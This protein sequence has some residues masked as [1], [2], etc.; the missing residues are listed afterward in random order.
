MRKPFLLTV[1][2][3]LG[4]YLLLPLPG[5]SSSLDS[6]IGKTRDRLAGKKHQEGILTT[7]LSHYSA[8]IQVL[9]GDIGEL[10]Q[11]QDRVQVSLN[12]KQA[13]LTRVS[14][15]HQIVQNRLTK[16]RAKLVAGR[17]LLARR[18]VAL[19]KDDQPDMV[20]VVLE[21][22]GFTDLLDR[23]D[24]IQRISDQNETI[25]T[26][27]RGLSHQ[28][29]M[30]EK[31]L[32]GLEVQATNARNTI[33]S[34]RNEIAGAKQTLVSRQADLVAAKNVRAGAL[35]KVRSSRQELEGHLGDLEA[36]QARIQ[37]RLQNASAGISAG[38]IKRGSGQ[39]IWPVNGPITSGF[40]G[41]NIGAGSEFHPGL[42]IGA[43]M[44][45][46]I[47]AAGAGTITLQQPE[48]ASGGYGNF[49]CISHTSSI[50]TCYGHQSKFIAHAGQHVSQGQ[51]IG[52]VGCTGR[53]FGAHLHFEVRVNGS[54][55]NPLGYL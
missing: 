22:H 27:V 10:Q 17:A 29:G 3:A 44:G 34:K 42:D 16:L 51:V 1:T 33:L 47:R 31:R 37:A 43:P 5:L 53:C 39:F 48:S 2:M 45:T 19:Y 41:R 28:V 14:N 55:V 52:L 35:A 9:R 15:R 6:R 26:R 4:L 25:V 23:A 36:Q 50:S 30:A 49:T 18:L 24:F 38:P 7:Q 11:R 40:G 20:T 8:R 46:P 12:A 21:S 13:E 54:V 32:H